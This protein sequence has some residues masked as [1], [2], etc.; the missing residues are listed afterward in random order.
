[1]QNRVISCHFYGVSPCSLRFSQVQAAKHIS[2]DKRTH[3]S[4]RTINQHH[5]YIIFF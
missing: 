1:M 2:V 5:Y 4:Q 3:A